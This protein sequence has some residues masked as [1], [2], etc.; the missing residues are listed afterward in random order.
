MR[1]YF[2]NKKTKAE[3]L[4][5]GFV[6]TLFELILWELIELI[7]VLYNI[8]IT[9]KSNIYVDFETDLIRHSI[10]QFLGILT[11]NF[12]R[13]VELYKVQSYTFCLSGSPL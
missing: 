12:K 13:S 7:R 8:I 3:F 11:E 2:R 5:E 10:V 1:W 4:N 6:K 9:T